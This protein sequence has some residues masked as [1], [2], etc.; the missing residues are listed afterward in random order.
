[1]KSSMFIQPPRLIF[2]DARGEN[3]GFPGACRGFKAF[4][5]REDGAYGI[6]PL[7]PAF[8]RD[9]LPLEQEAEEV[10]CFN[11]LDLGTQ[12][13]DGVA[14]D[15]SQQAAFAPLAFRRGARSELAAHR[16]PFGL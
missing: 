6:G 14:M 16:E 8:G 3:L 9:A 13:F 12:S 2:A 10:T 5:L 4:Q 15:A 1:M 11:G 7:H